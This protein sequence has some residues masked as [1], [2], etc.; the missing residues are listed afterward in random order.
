MSVRYC[1][2]TQVLKCI[3]DHVDADSNGIVSLIEFTG[4]CIKEAR[5]CHVDSEE[6][7]GRFHAI[8]CDGSGGLDFDEFEEFISD[9][10]CMTE[11]EEKAH[12]EEEKQQHDQGLLTLKDAL[13]IYIV[14]QVQ[15]HRRAKACA[16]D[17]G[18]F[19]CPTKVPMDGASLLH[20]QR[21]AL[22]CL[23]KSINPEAR[24]VLNFWFPESLTAAMMMWFGKDP[25]LDEQIRTD[26]GALIE[27]AAEG[28]LD[29]WSEDP[30]ECLALI[31]LLDQMPRNIHRHKKI[32]YATDAKAQA[33]CAKVLYHTY[34][35][36]ISPLQA[37]FMPCLVL[38]HSE[39]YHHQELCVD[40]WCHLIQH[41]LP[42]DDPLR[43]F[44]MIFLNHL[45]VVARF[46][47]F[48]HRND[49][50][51]RASTPEERAFLN[52]KS[53]RFDL[54][55]H[56]DEN[57][58]VVFEETQ[59]FNE[60]AAAVAPPPVAA[61]VEPA[62]TGHKKFG[63]FHKKEKK[64]HVVEA[65]SPELKKCLLGRIME[66]K[67]TLEQKLL[68]TNDKIDEKCHKNIGVE[69]AKPETYDGKE[70]CAEITFAR[71][72]NE[73]RTF[74]SPPG[75]QTNAAIIGGANGNA[76]AEHVP[77]TRSTAAQRETRKDKMARLLSPS[78]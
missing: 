13:T 17:G 3:F 64:G 40:I 32:M 21:L 66:W 33:L 10:V 73:K 44:G 55:L 26:F 67:D 6:L 18:E 70:D 68:D 52:D 46:G 43:I 60:A 36:M 75:S 14:E 9:Y 28:E 63:L 8:D 34:H 23:E 58:K 29:S 39:E 15:M 74:T 31:I 54:P 37:I 16:S 2:G 57:G 78:S 20:R 5:Q 65:D 41:S 47:R 25:A 30:C 22:N 38:T 59:A 72:E 35:K 69:A 71:D 4:F 48:P 61:P 49:I 42:K 51:E 7:R 27:A 12:E 77:W 62:S 19:V 45:K 76:N 24:R 50:M 53:F 56:Y 11:V 1:D